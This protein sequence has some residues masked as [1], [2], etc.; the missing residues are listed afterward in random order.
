MNLKDKI[1]AGVKHIEAARETYSAALKKYESVKNQIEKIHNDI[2]ITFKNTINNQIGKKHDHCRPQYDDAWF[3]VS[4]IT[5]RIDADHP[6]DIRDHDWNWDQIDK[7][8]GI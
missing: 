1:S 4:G 5:M 2:L 8:L 6:N 3:G 7:I